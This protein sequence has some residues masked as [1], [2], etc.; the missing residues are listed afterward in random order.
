MSAFLAPD[1][2]PVPHGYS[3]VASV[4]AGRLVFVSGKLGVDRGGSVADG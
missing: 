2:L 1:D 4:P 3:H